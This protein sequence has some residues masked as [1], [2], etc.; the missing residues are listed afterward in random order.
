M[1]SAPDPADPGLP[2]ALLAVL[3]GHPA[4][5]LTHTELAVRVSTWSAGGTQLSPRSVVTADSV[6]AAARTLERDGAVV[7][8]RAAWAD[9]HLPEMVAVA[10]ADDGQDAAAAR[11]RHCLDVL[12]R[13][14]LR[15]HR[16]T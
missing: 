8:A 7:T 14:L 10:L 6:L 1:T 11:A 5:T 13:Q 3:R 4:G 2:L 12:E 16:C 15:S 9:P